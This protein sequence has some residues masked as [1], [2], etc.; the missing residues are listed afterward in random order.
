[1]ILIVF[2]PIAV[3]VG[4]I[5]LFTHLKK[6]IPAGEASRFLRICRVISKRLCWR[7][8]NDYFFVGIVWIGVFS[9]ASYR[10]SP[11]TY[12]YITYVFATI[13]ILVVVAAIAFI[14]YIVLKT[15]RKKKR[16]L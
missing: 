4:S 7:Y 3:I 2:L 1:M 16:D 12:T 5:Y 11:N 8:L 9:T 13:C 14:F 6:D 15:V 10:N